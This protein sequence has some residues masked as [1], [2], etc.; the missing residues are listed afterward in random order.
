[1][2]QASLR[3]LWRQWLRGYQAWRGTLSALP[4]GW[5]GATVTALTEQ[6]MS[7][8]YQLSL[9][10]IQRIEQRRLR[11]EWL[12]AAL[13][14]VSARQRDGTIIYCDPTSRCALV[15]NPKTMLVVTALKL[16]PAKFRRIY[17]RSRNHYGR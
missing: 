14:G 13:E 16:R 7:G 12:V 17:S 3:A 8:A 2:A 4:R 6:S 11:A 1:M 9:H 5:V 10:A 15:I